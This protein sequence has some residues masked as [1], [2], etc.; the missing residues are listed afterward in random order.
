[1]KARARTRAVVV[2]GALLVLV[3][4]CS[5]TEGDDRAETAGAS[6]SASSSESSVATGDSTVGDTTTE[7]TTVGDTST[8]TTGADGVVA[9]WVEHEGG[10]DCRCADGSDFSY[11]SHDADPSKVLLYFQG[12]GACF[13]AETCNFDSGTYSVQAEGPGDLSG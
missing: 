3:A 7:T 8:E 5:S 10:P 1:M 4:S 9:E 11:W 6:T 12:G 13:S 2:L